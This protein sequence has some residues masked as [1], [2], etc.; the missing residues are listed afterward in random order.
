MSHSTVEKRLPKAA[1]KPVDVLIRLGFILMSRLINRFRCDEEG[2]AL[3]EYGML[4][5]LIAVVCIA[6]VSLLGSDISSVF[7]TVASKLAT[8]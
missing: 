5:G 8:V 6:A 4:I 7:S 3:A 1:S 2:A